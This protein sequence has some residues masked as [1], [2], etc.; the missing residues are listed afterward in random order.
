M[1]QIM[2]TLECNFNIF[3]PINVAK[4]ACCLI[5]T[6]LEPLI[7]ISF[8]GHADRGREILQY[9]ITVL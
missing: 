5:Y 2:M 3:A 1:Q 7:S 8:S 4:S 9:V 6:D